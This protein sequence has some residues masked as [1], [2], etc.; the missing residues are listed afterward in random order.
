MVPLQLL[1]LEKRNN[2]ARIK[3]LLSLLIINLFTVIAYA[4]EIDIPE[5][6]PSNLL[7]IIIAVLVAVISAV[8]L[9]RKKN[10]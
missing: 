8:L 5:E 10:K 9:L 2:M 6:K 3:Y 1:A 7:W 4:D